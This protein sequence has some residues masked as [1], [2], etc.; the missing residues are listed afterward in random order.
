MGEQLIAPP[1]LEVPVNP[2]IEQ[3]KADRAK[4]KTITQSDGTYRAMLMLHRAGIAFSLKNG[5]PAPGAKPA[6]DGDPLPMWFCEIRLGKG[7]TICA[8]SVFPADACKDVLRQYE[9]IGG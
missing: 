2:E 9:Q 8:Q 5:I 3:V 1:V 6:D 7:K 4:L